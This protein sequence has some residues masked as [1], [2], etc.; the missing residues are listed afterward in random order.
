MHSYSFN[1]IVSNNPKQ[2]LPVAFR[3]E[4]NHDHFRVCATLVRA[5][6]SGRI[7][8]I[9]HINDRA[10]TQ[11]QLRRQC[12][13][14]RLPGVH[15][16]PPSLKRSRE[17]YDIDRR[18]RVRGG[19]PPPPPPV[20][21]N[22]Q[23]NASAKKTGATHALRDERSV[24]C[25]GRVKI[26]KPAQDVFAFGGQREV[27][28]DR[29]SQL[30]EQ[31]LQGRSVACISAGTEV[32]NPRTAAHTKHI[33]HDLQRYIDNGGRNIV[34]Y[35]H[36]AVTIR[37]LLHLGADRC[38]PI[39]DAC[40]DH[41]FEAEGEETDPCPV[42]PG[43]CTPDF[44]KLRA[45]VLLGC[46]LPASPV[47]ESTRVIVIIGDHEPRAGFSRKQG[48][49]EEKRRLHTETL[50]KRAEELNVE[51]HIIPGQSHYLTVRAAAGEYKPDPRVASIVVAALEDPGPVPSTLST[52]TDSVL[53]DGSLSGGAVDE[54]DWGAPLKLGAA[55]P[56]SRLSDYLPLRHLDLSAISDLL[57]ETTTPDQRRAMQRYTGA[58]FSGI[59][60][61]LRRL[62]ADGHAM[63]ARGSPVVEAIRQIDSVFRTV[64]PLSYPLKVF[65][66]VAFDA[67]EKLRI[68]DNQRVGECNDKL[69]G[70]QFLSC[71]TEVIVSERF[72]RGAKERRYRWAGAGLCCFVEIN[73]PAGYRVIPLEWI[74]LVEDESEVLLPRDVKLR[75]LG[76]GVRSMKALWPVEE[77]RA[78]PLEDA[79]VQWAAAVGSPP[80]RE[81]RVRDTKVQVYR[82]EVCA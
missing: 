65:R 18:T 54:H 72:V 49:E 13:V 10:L 78:A 39:A 32:Y 52:A 55:A 64:R 45:I 66:G 7:E 43:A 36:G 15:E 40:A 77:Q 47:P 16:E 24:S 76:T 67:A 51:L 63:P 11:E 79:G 20:P 31:L 44:S 60:G 74:S 23:K 69:A 58:G 5:I 81:P 53:D 27:G 48:E 14:W 50:H 42:P 73:I 75:F 19:A 35:S 80:R 28:D 30:L 46:G 21:T 9:V 8:G 68:M 6:Q 37:N 3:A 71:S 26:A 62:R 70:G 34:A 25:R 4:D 33:S 22:K 57:R 41:C 59:N 82:Y 29:C 1:I 38:P 61:Y 17:D 56:R 2:V 12:A